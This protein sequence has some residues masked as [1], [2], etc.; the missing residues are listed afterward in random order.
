LLQRVRVRFPA[1][2]HPTLEPLLTT[3]AQ[4]ADAE[5]ARTQ[6][7]ALATVPG[8]ALSPVPWV[9]PL[10]AVA[11]ER[12]H[13]ELIDA[14]HGGTRPRRWGFRGRPG[15]AT[16]LALRPSKP[17]AITVTW[18]SSCSRSSSTA[19]KMMVA[20]GSTASWMSCAASCTSKWV[21]SQPVM[22]KSTPVAPAI[23]TA[24]KGVLCGNLIHGPVLAG[25]A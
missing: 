12:W 8:I 11:Q 15:A 2:L 20:S 19:P 6:L 25:Y 9:L 24:S 3:V 14:A 23:D 18:I 17:V 13:V 16:A 7:T 10:T 5:V 1:A 4:G 22:V 21:Y